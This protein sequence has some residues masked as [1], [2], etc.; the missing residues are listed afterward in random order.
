MSAH[1]LQQEQLQTDLCKY[2]K[3]H[4]RHYSERGGYAERVYYFVTS[5]SLAAVTSL[6]L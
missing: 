4:A 5:L 3:K 6:L 1:L 2:N